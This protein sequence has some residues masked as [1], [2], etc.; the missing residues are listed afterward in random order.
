[1]TAGSDSHRGRAGTGLAGDVPLMLIS[2]A[3]KCSR[4]GARKAHCWPKPYG[5]GD[6]IYP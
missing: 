2:I 5:I 1:M 6:R 3:L 4:C